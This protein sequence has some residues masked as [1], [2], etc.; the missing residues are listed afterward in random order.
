MINETK[1]RKQAMAIWEA[2]HDQTKQE[3]QSDAKQLLCRISSLKRSFDPI[4]S[5][6]YQHCV[7]RNKP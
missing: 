1:Y 2:S 7:I 3:L 5:F 4:I 6:I